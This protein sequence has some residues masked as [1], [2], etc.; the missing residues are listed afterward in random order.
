MSS[1]QQPCRCNLCLALLR[2]A[3]NAERNRAEQR[4]TLKPV[5][6]KAA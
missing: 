2:A 3:A 1:E 4:R 6:G 5:K